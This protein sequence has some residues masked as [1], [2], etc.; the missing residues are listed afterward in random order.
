VSEL[1]IIGWFLIV[2]GM[3]FINGIIFMIMVDDGFTKVIQ[4]Y[5]NTNLR[6]LAL[7]E[8]LFLTITIPAQLLAILCLLAA[9]YKP[10]KKK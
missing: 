6:D 10:F 2:V 3:L 9:S 7:L 1:F 4:D 8:L 5:K